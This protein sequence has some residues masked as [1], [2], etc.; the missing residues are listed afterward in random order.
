MVRD[1][2]EAYWEMGNPSSQWFLGLLEQLLQVVSWRE[3]LARSISE[4]VYSSWMKDYPR[5]LERVSRMRLWPSQ[6]SAIGQALYIL[7]NCGSLLVADPTG[8]GKSRLGVALQIL[9]EARLTG[10]GVNTK[11]RSPLLF[12]L[13]WYNGIGSQNTFHWKWAHR[14]YYL[15]DV[16]RQT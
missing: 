8:A 9:L 4:V 14:I 11:H 6:R 15:R 2:A 12:V 16:F 7:D 5:L 3:A 1:V 13:R 10:N